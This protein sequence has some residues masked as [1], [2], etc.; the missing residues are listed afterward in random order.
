[1][2]FGQKV[3]GVTPLI[4]N[5]DDEIN[6][7]EEENKIPETKSNWNSDPFGNTSQISGS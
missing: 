7:R 4:K 2:S 1:M 6:N 5:Y 3:P